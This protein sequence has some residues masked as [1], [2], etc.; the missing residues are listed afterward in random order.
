MKKLKLENGA[1]ISE[2]LATT[3]ENQNHWDGDEHEKFASRLLSRLR[4]ENGEASNLDELQRE[5]LMLI[6][7]P[8]EER[9]TKVLNLLFNSAEYE[10]DKST[11]SA[12]VL[13]FKRPSTTCSPKRMKGRLPRSQRVPR[14]NQPQQLTRQ[15][16]WENSC[17]ACFAFLDC[18][19]C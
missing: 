18:T 7:R 3:G 9:Q 12:F 1:F 17:M 14:S 6:V 13:L 15:A 10:L 11:E 16:M 4:D 5:T 8:T 19:Q 2:L